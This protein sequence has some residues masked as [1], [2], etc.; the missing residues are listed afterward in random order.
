MIN[1]DEGNS[2]TNKTTTALRKKNQARRKRGIANVKGFDGHYE[3]REAALL[4][5]EADALLSLDTPLNTICG[6]VV[7][8]RQ[9][10]EPLKRLILRDTLSNGNQ[11]ANDASIDRT[12][13]LLKTNF[14]IA[15]MAV[16]AA[17][18]IGA[19]NS[20]EKMLAH[21]MTLCHK[22]SFEMLDKALS[23][24]DTV[25]Q[26]RL[27][28]VAARLMTTFQQGLATIQK[29][30]NGG[31]Q[32]VTVQHVHIETGAQAVI[33]NLQGGSAGH[34]ANKNG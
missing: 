29:L 24:R 30:R 12:D 16:D 9:K 28:N 18:T 4:E 6:E 34:G 23:Q 14:D 15:A 21:Q 10:G 22:A 8:V 1:D 7:S 26:A 33:G 3:R 19:D 11:I 2:S 5:T 13:L 31:N 25:E 17:E 27:A 20:L 32:T